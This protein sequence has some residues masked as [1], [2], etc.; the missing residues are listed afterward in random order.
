MNRLSNVHERGVIMNEGQ[1]LNNLYNE[2]MKLYNK[3]TDFIIKACNK[4]NLNSFKTYDYGLETNPPMI[5]YTN[6]HD[7]RQSS[8]P[9]PPL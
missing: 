2:R 6:K 9:S 8:R 7:Y 4:V 1:D 3:H 5:M